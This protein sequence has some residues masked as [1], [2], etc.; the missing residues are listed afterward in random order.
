MTGW[1]FLIDASRGSAVIG[2][3]SGGRTEV[4]PSAATLKGG[5][6]AFQV[7]NGGANLTGNLSATGTITGTDCIATSDERLKDD[8]TTAP[9]GLIDGLTGR[10]WVWKESGNKGSGV[11]AQEL[12]KVLPHLVHTNDQGIKSVS[13]MGLC[14]YLIEEIKALK[15]EV[16]ALKNG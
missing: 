16:E 7:L 6:G 11:V 5:T 10:E 1:Q 12:E 2:Y 4:S 3:A 14:G 13:Y 8:I 9:V 15:A